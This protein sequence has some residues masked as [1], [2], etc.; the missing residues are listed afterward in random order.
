MP[1]IADIKTVAALDEFMSVPHLD[2]IL[3][4]ESSHA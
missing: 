4:E 2:R 3:E 1:R